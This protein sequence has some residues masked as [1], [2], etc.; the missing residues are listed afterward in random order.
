MRACGKIVA[1]DPGI[2]I[3]KRGTGKHSSWKGLKSIDGESGR[4]MRIDDSCFDPSFQVAVK[5]TKCAHV[6]AE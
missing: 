1:N 3:L 2:W 6:S 4:N 5:V